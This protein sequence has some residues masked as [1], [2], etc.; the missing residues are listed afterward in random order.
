[1]SPRTWLRLLFALAALVL[2]GF[3]LPGWTQPDRGKK[4]AL[5]VGV[6][7]YDSDK[8]EDLKYPENDVEELAKVLT[9][10]AG[11]ISVRV[12]STS[13]GARRTADAPTAA[14]VRAAIKALL[15]K[16][17]KEDTVLVALSGHGI[18]A[19]LKDR[20]ESFFCPSDA[21]LNDH[22]TLVSLG[23]L[24]AD[25]DDCGARVKLLLV[26]AC[27]NDPKLG[28]NV[29]VET[30]PRLPRGTAAL[31]SCSAG[32]RAFETDKL[33]K[34]HGVFF[35]HVLQGLKGAAKNRDGEVT[36]SGLSEHVTRQVSRQVPALIGGGARQ[37]P[38]LKVNLRGES[39]L[40]VG[41]E[42][43][44]VVKEGAKEIS[45]SIGMKLVRIPPSTFQMG[46]TKEEQD[47]AI[48]DYEKIAGSKASET[49]VAWYRSEGPRHEVEITRAFYMG[50]HEVTQAQYRRVMGSNPSWFSAAG[51]G[52]DQ[53]KGMDTDDF[54]VEN[55][56]Y[57][58]ALMFCKKLSELPAEQRAKRKYR[59]PTE[60]EWEY[61]C[62]GGAS[63]SSP[64]HFGS[65]LSS[66]QANFDGNYPYGGAD[67][68]VYLKRTCKVGEH[69]KNRFGLHDMH[70]NVWE[71]CSDWY[72]ADYYGKSPRL[73]PKGPSEGSG[74]VIRGGG[75]SD[76]GQRCRSADRG[77][78]A[79]TLRY[80][81]LG[82]RVAQVPSDDR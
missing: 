57:E 66:T 24:I 26:D 31:F 36:W 29:D 53:V 63:S 30:L 6:R 76:D 74:R 77:R 12:L 75:W 13:R 61:S 44:E 2:L 48:A 7:T 40:L 73:D 64:F 70:G 49:T 55:V 25:L 23:K 15:A 28:R 17:K 3:V 78:N 16:K 27:R 58:G 79:P 62:R 39:P 43:A 81:Y 46:S 69:A 14:N 47:A 21:Q 71:W 35:F 32:E 65:S 82:F 56:S 34:G 41:P 60:A 8:F 59:L 33:G 9:D 68:D 67:K 80:Y 18:Q 54:P 20:D 38:E 11:F 37:T 72:G 52:K 42:K 50:M 10:R 22:D 51:R 5:L 1:M 19:K 45:N 4:H